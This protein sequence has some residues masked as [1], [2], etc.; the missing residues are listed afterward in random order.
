MPD[1]QATQ[2][3]GATAISASSTD[4]PR[5]PRKRREPPATYKAN[6]LKEPLISL[7]KVAQRGISFERLD[8]GDL[9]ALTSDGESINIKINK[10]QA[11]QRGVALPYSAAGLTVYE[12]VQ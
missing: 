2:N 11:R 9:F 7:G 10:S 1:I 5:V 3:G 12:Y 6:E 8:V 4:K